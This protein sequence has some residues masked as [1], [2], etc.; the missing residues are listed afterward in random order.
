MSKRYFGKKKKWE[1]RF[2]FI[3]LVVAAVIVL[4]VAGTYLYS[5]TRDVLPSIVGTPAGQ[6]TQAILAEAQGLLDKGAPDDAEKALKPLLGAGDPVATPQ[7]VILQAA[8]EKGRGKKDEALRLLDEACAAFQGS[9]EFPA[10]AASK[11][12]T[13]EELE[14]FEEARPIYESIRDNA[15]P[16]MRAMGLLGLALAEHGGDK[17][18]HATFIAMRWMTPLGQRRVE[19]GRGGDGQTQRGIDL[20]PRRNPP[21]AGTMVEKGDSLISIGMKLN[22]TRGC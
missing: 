6:D 15:P 19:R 16:E 3:M 9:P 17:L 4:V 22:T 13:L 10:L 1:P 12:R 11:A 14:R 5:R 2:G 20:R 21:K 7:A 18:P 8:I